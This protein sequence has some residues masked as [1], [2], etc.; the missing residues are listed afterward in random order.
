MI[1]RRGFSYLLV[2]VQFGAIGGLLLTGPWLAQSAAGLFFQ[3]MAVVLGIWAVWTMRRF[4]IVPDP[5]PD[6][7]LICHGPYRWVRHPMYLSLLLFFMPLVVGAPSRL[8]WGL[9]IVLMVDL[10]IKLL[11]EEKLLRTQLDEYADYCTRSRR[12]IPFLW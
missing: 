5:R 10:I 11:Y 2:V 3:S 4:N 9:F 1:F 8:R 12:L 7:V 6:C